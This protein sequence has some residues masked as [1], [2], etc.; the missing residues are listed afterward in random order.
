VN[1]LT[2]E[3]HLHRTKGW[4]IMPLTVGASFPLL[5]VL[6]TGTPFSAISEGAR[7]SLRAAG[8]L[9]EGNARAYVLRDL[10][11]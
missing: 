7:D 6:D 4:I 10:T 5:M 3:T 1:D 9:G 2:V 11:I 8:L